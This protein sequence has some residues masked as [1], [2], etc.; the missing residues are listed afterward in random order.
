[1]DRQDIID[2]FDFNRAY[3]RRLF[4]SVRER[5]YYERPIPL[6]QPVVFYEG[7]FSAFNLNTLVKRALKKPG[8]DERL[9]TLFERGIDPENEVAAEGGEQWPDPAEIQRFVRATDSTV[10]DALSRDGLDRQAAFLY[11]I[12]EHEEMHHETFRYMLHRLP[13]E[14]KKLQQRES[15]RGGPAPAARSVRIPPGQATLGV[16]HDDIRFGWDNEFDENQVDVPA[17][18]IDVFN[19]TNASYLEFV[20]AGGYRNRDLWTQDG[21]DWLQSHRI[22]KP[23]FWEQDSKK[24]LWRGMTRYYELPLAWPVYATQEEASAYARWRGARLPTEAE[25]HRAAFGTPSGAE[26]SFPWG[27]EAP[28]RSRGNF[29]DQ[30]DDPL[31]VGSFPAGQSAFG[32]HDL[33]G[34]GWEWTSSPFAPFPGFEPMPSYPNYSVDFFDGKH[35]VLKGASPSTSRNLVRRSFRNWFRP[36][37]P[38]VYATFR[39][40]RS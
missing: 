37:Y 2:R 27:E 9:E 40:V 16:R 3:S 35:Y 26:R 33:I 13:F 17:F 39:C 28:D 25:Y 19:V 32:V 24:W 4:D 30:F 34:N 18:W 1:M 12:L 31:P 23:L 15:P 36:N 29:D 7:H 38:Y 8:V 5:A 10:R 22:E 6:R 11:T 14:K 21:W 20:E